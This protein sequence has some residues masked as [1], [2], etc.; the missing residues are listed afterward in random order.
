MWPAGWV[1][2]RYAKTSELGKDFDRKTLLSYWQVSPNYASV[3]LHQMRN[4][5][6][7]DRV[8]R[9]KYSLVPPEKWLNLGLFS[10]QHPEV[11]RAL[12]ELLRDQMN[13]IESLV[14]YGS[15]A[16]GVGDELS[17]WDFLIVAST[18]AKGQMLSRLGSIRER[19][20]LFTPEIL[21]LEGFK[22]CLRKALVFLKVVNREGKII[23]DSG[24]MG[25]V[26]ASQV[27]PINV[28]H[29]LLDA[30][31][32]I[33]MGIALL[34]DGKTALACYRA[35]RGVRLALLAEL[36]TRGIFSG[37]DIG[38]EFMREFPEF[39]ELMEAYRMI[40]AGKD[41]T[42]DSRKLGRLIDRA[43]LT[44]EKT[45]EKAGEMVGEEK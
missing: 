40:K 11:S 43:I 4:L 10:A 3:S 36:A 23:F 32:N 5:L 38:R 42:V 33:L 41:A 34:K 19:N 45:R 2:E 20:P 35:V 18:E 25:L 37:E 9:A 15:R 8:D 17:D 27:K 12:Y 28:A 6:L 22:T 44:W 7:I 21:D 30:K 1:V 24:L 39:V 31:R 14:F 13:H 26:E 29:E 16:R